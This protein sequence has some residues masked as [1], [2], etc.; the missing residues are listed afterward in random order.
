MRIKEFLSGAQ[1][2]VSYWTYKHEKYIIKGKLVY[3]ALSNEE[4]VPI[5]D[6]IDIRSRYSKFKRVDQELLKHFTDHHMREDFFRLTQKRDRELVKIKDSVDL[7]VDFIDTAERLNPDINAPLNDQE[8]ET[9]TR[10]F[11][12]YGMLV[13]QPPKRPITEYLTNTLSN[14][15]LPEFPD[16]KS[17]KDTIGYESIRFASLLFGVRMQL[18]HIQTLFLIWKEMIWQPT[19]KNTIAI[20]GLLTN[21]WRNPTRE[22]FSVKDYR[23]FIESIKVRHEKKLVFLG[24]SIIVSSTY[25]NALEAAVGTMIGIIE[26]GEDATRGKRL[27]ICK[28]CGQEYIQSHGLQQYC[29]PHREPAI[30][31]S[32][33][34]KRKAS[35]K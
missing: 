31:T 34:R 16:K 24:N 14:S 26:Q 1:L 11:S 27:A 21:I 6:E 9:L 19:R 13:W 35:T 5:E 3:G 29:E 22:G 23:S 4:N 12:K 25:E 15:S 8:K 10:L 17:G 33:C 2:P 32:E 20:S 18:A 7:L 28:M 30:R